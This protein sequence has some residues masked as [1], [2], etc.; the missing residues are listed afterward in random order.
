MLLE[1]YRNERL[2]KLQEI[3]ERG[4][5]PYPSVSHRTTKISEIMEGF[6]ARKGQEVSVVGRITAIRSFGKLVFIKL[7]DYTGEI[8]IFMR[9]VPEETPEKMFGAKD[10]KLLDTGDFIEA[11]GVVDKTQTGEISVFSNFVKLLTKSLRPLP[12]QFT[13]KE[14]RYRRRYVDMN[15][16]PGVRERLVRRS[17]FWQ[18][19]RNF[20]NSHGFIEINI[21]VLEHTTGG[22]DAEPFV[23]HMNA[24]DEDFYLRISHELPLKRLL[25]GGFEKV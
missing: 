21:P 20:M 17:K 3:R 25:G 18:A 9:V 1:D 13:N 6:D 7:R 12:Q 19:T 11:T 5:N 15:V 16:N 2:R 10:I 24:L 23:T 8:Q 14:E 22:A 4:I